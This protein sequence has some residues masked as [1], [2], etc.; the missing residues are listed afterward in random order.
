[1]AYVDK[2]VKYATQ[3][4]HF[5]SAINKDVKKRFYI[6]THRKTLSHILQF[7]NFI[8]FF[9]L[10]EILWQKWLMLTMIVLQHWFMN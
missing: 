1:V 10:F 2:R 5:V 3:H 9:Y 6:P 7:Y 4:F 8:I